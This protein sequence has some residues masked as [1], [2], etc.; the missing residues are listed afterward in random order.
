[1]ISGFIIIISIPPHPYSGDID[2]VWSEEDHE[3]EF[4]EI[5]FFISPD[6]ENEYKAEHYNSKNRNDC[7]HNSPLSWAKVL[8]VKVIKFFGIISPVDKNQKH[9]QAGVA[10]WCIY[11][12]SLIAKQAQYT[13][14]NILNICPIKVSPETNRHTQCF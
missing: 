1:M 4:F 9:K 7:F 3:D 13:L 10:N 6:T 14:V 5:N 11:Y 8:I 2:K 12:I